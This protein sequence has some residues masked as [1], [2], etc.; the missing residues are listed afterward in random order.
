MGTILSISAS[1]PEKKLISSWTQDLQPPFQED[2]KAK[3]EYKDSNSL[4][5]YFLWFLTLLWVPRTIS[6]LITNS[7]NAYATAK[8]NAKYP[9]RLSHSLESRFNSI[10]Q[11][12][13]RAEERKELR[14]AAGRAGG[15]LRLPR[16][17]ARRAPA[18]HRAGLPAMNWAR[19]WRAGR[20][21]RRM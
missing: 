3:K 15:A 21:V 12:I 20:R 1:S 16:A 6:H 4:R 18:T 9:P 8:A 17:A 19:I 11:I 7:H 2:E 14:S 5:E 13:R 10:E